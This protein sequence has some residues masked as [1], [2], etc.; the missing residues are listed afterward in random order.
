VL[1]K[2]SSKHLLPPGL[3]SLAALHEGARDGV[4]VIIMGK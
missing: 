2:D 3:D 4:R 1:A